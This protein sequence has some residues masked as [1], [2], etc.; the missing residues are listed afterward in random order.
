MGGSEVGFKVGL[1][2]GLEVGGLVGFLVVAAV[3]GF[4][5]RGA[6]V[7]F[8]IGAFE[9]FFVVGFLVV[10]KLDFAVRRSFT[11]SD[12]QLRMKHRKIKILLKAML[13]KF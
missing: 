3:V 12:K 4:V 8:E 2:E 10:A 11:S 6:L 7:G 13:F 5:V 9:G 1:L